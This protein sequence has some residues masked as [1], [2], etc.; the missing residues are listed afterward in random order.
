MKSASSGELSSGKKSGPTAFSFFLRAHRSRIEA[1]LEPLLTGDA[2]EKTALLK[3]KLMDAWEM[4]PAHE[5]EEFE[6]KEA[7]S[8]AKSDSAK[9][10]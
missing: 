10:K 5:R 4:L 2:E 9:T 8:R 7:E 1:E 3:E 6:Q